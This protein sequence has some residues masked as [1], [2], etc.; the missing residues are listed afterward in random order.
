MN[1][2]RLNNL[3]DCL[4]EEIA[5]C[6][7]G[8]QNVPMFKSRGE[9]RRAI[10]HGEVFYT[11]ETDN[12]KPWNKWKVLD[13]DIDDIFFIIRTGSKPP[14]LRFYYSFKTTKII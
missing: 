1:R 3:I 10:E 9:A 8:E 6:T 2:D 13:D 4:T 12:P 11:N 14:N 5:I 7:F